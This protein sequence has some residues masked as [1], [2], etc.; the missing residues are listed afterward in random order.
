MLFPGPSRAAVIDSY[1][2]W[3]LHCRTLDQSCSQ[4]LEE[5]KPEQASQNNSRSDQ[6]YHEGEHTKTGKLRKLR[7][8]ISHRKSTP[9]ISAVHLPSLSAAIFGFIKYASRKFQPKLSAR[10]NSTDNGIVLKVPAPKSGHGI[11]QAQNVGG[12]W[13]CISRWICLFCMQSQFTGGKYLF[14]PRCN[15]DMHAG[16]AGKGGREGC[17]D[18]AACVCTVVDRGV[19]I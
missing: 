15:V 17:R 8:H 4:T 11:S 3:Q 1:L 14:A 2:K 13:C 9:C 6:P 7:S 10:K 18:C 12:I 16:T 19:V 5:G